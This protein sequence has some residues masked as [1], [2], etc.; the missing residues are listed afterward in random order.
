MK[1]VFIF[2][3]VASW[4]TFTGI[5]CFVPQIVYKGC[6]KTYAHFSRCNDECLRFQGI[7]QDPQCV[8]QRGDPNADDVIK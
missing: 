8:W 7:G 1:K 3:T 6:G 5:T 4:I 2:I